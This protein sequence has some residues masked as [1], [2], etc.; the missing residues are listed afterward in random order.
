L[1]GE[2]GI[3]HLANK[4]AVSWHDLAR[5]AAAFAKLDVH[6]V[7]STEAA[8]NADTSLTSTRGLLLRPLES[9]LSEYL[10]DAERA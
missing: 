10:A 4:G 2:T 7:R 3:W 1:D 8:H 6:K 5:E 9:A